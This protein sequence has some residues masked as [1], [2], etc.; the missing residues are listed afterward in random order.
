MRLTRWLCGQNVFAVGVVIALVALPAVYTGS[1]LAA[2]DVGTAGCA[3]S[4]GTEASPGFRAYLPECRAYELVTPPY[5]EGAE[6]T[7]TA[8]SEDGAHVIVSG[9][10]AFAGSV[11]N[12]DLAPNIYELSRTGAGWAASAL[13]PLTS[14]FAAGVYQDASAS[15]DRTLWVLHTAA[16]SVFTHDL[17]VREPDGSFVFVGHEL[18]PTASTGP[19]GPHLQESAPLTELGGS[20]D[21]SHVLFHIKASTE[22]GTGVSDLWPGDSTKIPTS[23][24]PTPPD[25]ESLYEYVGFGTDTKSPFLVGVEGGR[26][27][28]S[29]ISSCGTVLGSELAGAEHAGSTYNAIAE[30]GATVF[31]TALACE[32][33]PPVDELFARVNESSTV[34][35]SQPSNA[36]CEACEVSTPKPALFQGASKDGSKA[37]FLS[38]EKLLP[39]AEGMNLYEYDFNGQ[40]GKKVRLIASQ[41]P[42]VARIS[43]DGSHAYFVATS[44]LTAVENGQGQQAKAGADNLYVYERDGAFPNGHI[45]F[46]TALLSG[47]D[48]EDWRGVERRG[49]DN[50]PVQATPDGRFLA[51]VSHRR[52]TPDDETSEG[53]AQL[54]EYDAQNGELVRVSKG[55]SSVAFPAGFNRNG[56]VTSEAEAPRFTIPQYGTGG[57]GWV[58]AEANALSLSRDGKHVVFHSADALTPLAVSS[59]GRPACI[60]VYEYHSSGPIGSGNVDLISDGQDLTVGTRGEQCGAFNE[61]I[62]P[63]GGNVFFET[64]DALVPQDTNT[65]GDLYDAR[66]GGGFPG[67]VSSV[68]CEGDACQGSLGATPSFSPSGSASLAPE[69]NLAPPVSGPATKT[70]AKPLTWA[71]KLTKALKACRTKHNKHKRKVCEAQAHKRY[72]SAHKAKRATTHRRASR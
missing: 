64:G 21:L 17:Y 36:D 6:V 63:S 11:D 31:F 62:D 3:A 52:L 26:G 51:F 44:V 46:V 57:S 5:K 38:E 29:L 54:F 39:G 15:F 69:G 28:T 56:N 68:G 42:G 65:Q 53:V 20:R 37:F 70:K 12:G 48:E 66:A 2:A 58:A 55:Q 34:A 72:R 67:P 40:A 47:V 27:S 33:A 16:Q 22:T 41:A 50:H 35:I 61:V 24:Q 10:G 9:L 71:Q 45:A 49:Q 59:S 32:G 43:Q 14:Q 1:A 60:N 18:P 23:G 25:G 13:D 8:V 4:P 30:S 7:R 19:P